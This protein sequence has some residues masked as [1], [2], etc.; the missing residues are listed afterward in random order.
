[1]NRF[2][3]SHLLRAIFVVVPMLVFASCGGSDSPGPTGPGP[4]PNPNPNP[5]PTPTTGLVQVS[6]AT[7]GSDL[8]PDGYS[9]DLDGNSGQAIGLNGVTTFTDVPAGERQVQLSGLA[10][11]CSVTGTN[12]ATVNVTASATAQVSFDI[13]CAFATGSLEVTTTVTNN[14]DPDGY[15]LSAG[16]ISQG[17]VDVNESVT[18]A[19][20]PLG[21]QQVELTDVAPNCVVGG[22]NP[23]DVTIVGGQTASETFNIV[24]T[25]PPDGRVLFWAYNNGLGDVFVVN[26]DG[27]GVL[28]LTNDHLARDIHPAWSADGEKIAFASDRAAGNFDIYVMNKDASGLIRITTHPGFDVEPA[29][30]PDGSRLAF[31]SERDGSIEIFLVNADGSGLTQLTDDTGGLTDASI[32]TWSPDGSRLAFIGFSRIT[33]QDNVYS[34]AVDGTGL[35]QLTGPAPTCTQTGRPSWTDWAPDW[36]PDGTRIVFM[37]GFDCDTEGVRLL[38][39]NADGNFPVDITPDGLDQPSIWPT[40]SP[41]GTKIVAGGDDGF[42]VMDVDG[43]N[44]AQQLVG[45]AV[46]DP[47]WGP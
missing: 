11:N 23:R 9:A 8:D 20:I 46:L 37:R 33:T 10:S 30:S 36:S 7:T 26:V 28:N 44:A 3:Q 15:Q 19:G 29:W 14:F 5:D 16:G 38:T 21:N 18:F 32:P 31:E 27:T 2:N 39:M 6:T 42:W 17:R 25:S 41:D 45:S 24:C 35:L 4:N 40:W 13:V 22:T 12:P 43:L 34:I 1:M 47:D